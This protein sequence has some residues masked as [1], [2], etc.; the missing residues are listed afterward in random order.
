MQRASFTTLAKT[1]HPVNLSVSVVPEIPSYFTGTYDAAYS[2]GDFSE[3]MLSVMNEY[4]T[5]TPITSGIQRCVASC[6]TKIRA[7]A[8]VPYRSAWDTKW[9]N[10]SASTLP[11]MFQTYLS[12]RFGET[13]TLDLLV[14][15]TG[16]EVA[17]TCAGPINT[18]HYYLRSAIAEYDVLITNGTLTLTDPAN[19]RFISWANNTA[20][21]NATIKQFELREH[22]SSPWI[23]TTLGGI[24]SAFAYQFQVTGWGVLTK[25]GI[26]NVKT[27]TQSWFIY[28]HATNYEEFEKNKACAL[29]FR[30][31]RPGIMAGLNEIMFRVGVYAADNYNQSFLNTRLDPGLQTTYN[32]T[33]MLQSPVEVFKSD[34]AYFVAAAAIQ[35]LTIVIVLSTFW[36]YWRLGR[37]VSFSPLEIAKVLDPFHSI[38]CH[39]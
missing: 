23:K 26:M 28:Q 9:H 22:A 19:P 35:Q 7:P 13:E 18:T 3:P 16:T 20:I 24:V 14:S 30:D 1:N 2:Q 10:F 6:T 39:C 4:S 32:V 38:L 5:Q 25:S 33:G 12:S 34:F 15:L 27:D 11:P 29:V 17:A 21:T 31:P 37:H 36:G 8:L